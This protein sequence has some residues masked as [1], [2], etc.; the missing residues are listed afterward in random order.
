VTEP[1]HGGNPSTPPPAPAPSASDAPRVPA[2][3]DPYEGFLARGLARV[4]SEAVAPYQTAVVRIGFALTWLLFLLRE[5]PHRHE[6]Y[7]PDG[8]WSWKL[9][10]RLIDSNHA[11]TVLMW[12]DSTLWFEFVYVLA[13]AASVAVIVGWRTRTA[14]VVYM[15]G[16]LGLQNRSVF[17]GDGGD[18]VIHLMAMY[19]ILTRCAEVWSLDARRRRRKAAAEGSSGAADGTP[20]SRGRDTTGAVLWALFGAIMLASTV[21]GTLSIGWGL[22][23]WALWA[24]HAVWWMANRYMPGSELR[25]VC[26]MLANLVH[27]AALLVIVVEVCLIYSTAGWYKIQGSR[28]QDGTAVY[29]PMNLDYFSPWPELSSFLAGSGLLIL[30]ATYGTVAVQVAFPFT[31]FNRRVKNVLLAAMIAEH[32]SIAVLLGLPFFSMA[33]IAADA[34]FLP[35]IALMWAGD[36]FQGGWERV[37]RRL[38]PGRGQGTYERGP[39]GGAGSDGG[40]AGSGSQVPQQRSGGGVSVR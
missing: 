7:G 39:G 10:E 18:N 8:P 23:F 9:A 16:V 37:L 26:D 11:F 19:V 1:Q 20:P 35:T 33:M 4:T 6:L 38:R 5:F 2:A 17:M 27:N 31:L 12:S 28:W 25:T 14:S 36:R 24:A 30:L 40:G 15:V 3:P 29:Y 13:V 22:F 34:V 21:G 32:C